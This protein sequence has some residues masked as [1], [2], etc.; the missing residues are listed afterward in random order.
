MVG[1]QILKHSHGLSDEQVVFQYR[2]NPYWQ[3]FCG[4]NNFEN[5]RPVVATS[6]TKFRNIIGKNGFEIIQAETIKIGFKEK[7]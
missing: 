2:E 5:K 7:L 6:L 3:Y 1:L 4:S